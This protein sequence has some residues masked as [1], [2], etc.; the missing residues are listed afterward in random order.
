[1]SS[2]EMGIELESFVN[3]GLREGWGGW[4]PKGKTKSKDQKI[5]Y[6]NCGI[7]A[8]RDDFLNSALCLSHLDLYLQW[9]PV[10]RRL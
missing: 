5:K 3:Q 10:G 1:M 6:Q 4:P 8:C 9:L 7:P 2:E